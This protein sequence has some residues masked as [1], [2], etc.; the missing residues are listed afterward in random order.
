MKRIREY[1][2]IISLIL[3][4]VKRAIDGPRVLREFAS[5]NDEICDCLRINDV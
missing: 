1:N 3:N 5:Q 2:Q 4:Y